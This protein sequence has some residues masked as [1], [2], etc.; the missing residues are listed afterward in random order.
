MY[1]WKLI[2]FSIILSIGL[3]GTAYAQESIQEIIEINPN[4]YNP[5]C[6]LID[7]CFSPTIV[8]I[9]NGD[10]I[11]W[12]NY[13]DALH[14][15]VSGTPGDGPSDIFTS[16]LL[17][18]GE[19]FEFNFEL[20]DSVQSYFCSIHPWMIGYIVIGNVEFEKPILEKIVDEPIIF[21][22]FKFE[23]FISG[24][25]T[26]VSIT[27]L[28]D[29]LLILQK[30]DGKIL[31]FKDGELNTVLDLEVSNYGEQGLL[32]ITTVDSTVYIFLT[33]AFH[34]GGLA[35]GNKIY[36]FEWDGEFLTQK[37]LLKDRKSVV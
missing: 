7:F 8:H 14:N 10:S 37:K 35:T 24:L 30:N 36:K 13:D 20:K 19:L 22:N 32:G 26:P 3:F 2:F 34:D 23:K 21:D 15:I 31:S 11:K 5:G 4:S 17:K 18:T 16:P 12:I 6:E 1:T 28:D 29:T 33:E 27:F 25:S 9:D